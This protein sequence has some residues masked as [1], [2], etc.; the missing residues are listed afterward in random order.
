LSKRNNFIYFTYSKRV[1]YECN[2]FNELKTRTVKELY[3]TQN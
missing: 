1:N 3:H 2:M